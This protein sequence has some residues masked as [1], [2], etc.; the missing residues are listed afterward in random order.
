MKGI[1]KFSKTSWHEMTHHKT[2]IKIDITEIFERITSN[3][4]VL[5]SLSSFGIKRCGADDTKFH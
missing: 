4:D 3:I 1:G 5:L 2:K